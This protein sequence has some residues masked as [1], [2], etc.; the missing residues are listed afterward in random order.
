[1]TRQALAVDKFAM[2]REMQAIQRWWHINGNDGAVD[3]DHMVDGLIG[4][5]ILQDAA[6]VERAAAVK[7][8]RDW[9]GEWPT[10]PDDGTFLADVAR[11]GLARADRIESE[12]RNV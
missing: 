3:P 6:E 9:I 8:L 12:A 1:M 11:D 7:A 10:T 4:S 5:G 2:I